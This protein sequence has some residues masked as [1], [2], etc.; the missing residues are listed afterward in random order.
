MRLV[1]CDRSVEEW[2]ATYI[3]QRI[4]AFAPTIDRPFVLGLPT[5]STPLGMYRS[6]I[7]KYERGEISFQNVVTFNLDEY[8]G[9]PENHPQSYHSY[10]YENFFN[11]VDIPTENIHILDGNASDLDRECQDYEQKIESIGGIA[12]FVGGV[13]ED[14]HIAFNEPGS[15]LQSRTRIKTLTHSTRIANARFFSDDLEQ[16]PKLALT[17]GV[18]TILA[19]REVMILAKG[20]AKAIAV[21]QAIEQGINRMWPIS[22]LQLH[23]HAIVVCDDAATSELKVKTVRYFQEMH[24]HLSDIKA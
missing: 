17:V 10:M 4:Q 15:S 11:H 21:A 2:A 1:I 18:G 6:L 14:G 12:L 8:V 3:Q 16:V 5:G 9:L 7:Q 20:Y 19:A 22:A 23:P 13:G 24:D